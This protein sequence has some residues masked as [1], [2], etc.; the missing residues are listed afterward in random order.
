MLQICIAMYLLVR[1]LSQGTEVSVKVCL[2]QLTAWLSQAALCLSM[3]A[4]GASLWAAQKALLTRPC[5]PSGRT[6]LTSTC[7]SQEGSSVTSL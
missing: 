7:L 3:L 5:Q 6:V 4:R 2:G 1:T